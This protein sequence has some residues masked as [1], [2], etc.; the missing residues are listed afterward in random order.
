VRGDG[1]EF[2][3]AETLER[4]R[5]RTDWGDVLAPDWNAGSDLG[6]Q[7]PAGAIPTTTETTETE[8]DSP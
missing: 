2:V 7:R 5:G 6:F 8:K 1:G 3:D 4:M